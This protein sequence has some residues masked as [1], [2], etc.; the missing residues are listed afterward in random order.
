M[1][2]IMV[3]KAPECGAAGPLGVPDGGGR[4]AG[5]GDAAGM[6]HYLLQL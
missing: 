6:L 4:G 5:D 2:T 3:K 1:V